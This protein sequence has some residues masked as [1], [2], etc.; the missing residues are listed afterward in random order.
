MQ[1]GLVV[2]TASVDR[3]SDFYRD[4]FDLEILEQDNTYAL[5]ADGAFE[6]VLLETQMSIDTSVTNTPR[7]ATPI[8]PSF[9]VEAPLELISSRI[10]ERGGSVYPA[11]PWEFGGRQVCDAY[12]CE[13]NIFQLR[14]RKLKA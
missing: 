13:G 2:Y 12:D 11:K 8:K 14:V 1:T 9:F 3:L 4:V 5:L 10:K 7:E 6:L